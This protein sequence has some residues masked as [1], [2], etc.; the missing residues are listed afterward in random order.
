MK[1]HFT[2]TVDAKT[3]TEA[4]EKLKAVT[5]LLSLLSEKELA[6]MAHVVKHDPIKTALAKTY[7]GL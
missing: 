1:H 5:T 6:R 3:G 7:L 4:E 2:V